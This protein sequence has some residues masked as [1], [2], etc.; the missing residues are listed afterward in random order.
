MSSTSGNNDN[1][2]KISLYKAKFLSEDIKEYS[3]EN[4]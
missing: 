3:I 4:A 1:C 2:I